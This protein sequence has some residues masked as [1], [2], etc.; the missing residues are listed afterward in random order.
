MPFHDFLLQILVISLARGVS[1][2]ERS[3]DMADLQLGS[4]IVGPSWPVR[5]SSRKF[6]CSMDA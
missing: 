6:S 2:D 5:M 3:D 4:V 1:G